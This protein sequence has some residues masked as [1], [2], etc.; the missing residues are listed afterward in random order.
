MSFRDV[1]IFPFRVF[2]LL[3]RLLSYIAWAP[4]IICLVT[5]RICYHLPR[6]LTN[7]P[8]VGRNVNPSQ[9]VTPSK[10]F[11]QQHEGLEPYQYEPLPGGRYIRL[12]QVKKSRGRDD[13][14]YQLHTM[15]LDHPFAGYVYRAISYAWDGQVP[16]RFIV[17][18][19]KKLAVTQNCETILRQMRR[20]AKLLMW[21][22]AVCIDLSSVNEKSTQ[23]PLMSKIYRRAFVVHIWMG[24]PT[25][26]SSI[27]F[28]YSWLLW[29]CLAFPEPVKSYL[30]ER[31]HGLILGT[32]ANLIDG[33]HAR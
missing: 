12:L 7:R 19:G 26:G 24:E 5:F 8:S 23:I 10:P 21:I 32:F 22:D 29:C 3:L 31:V 28:S 30:Q 4:Y 11:N 16:D 14:E 27:V 15:S 6:I 25:E 33:T 9:L 13:V 20:H 2:I 17:C 1:Y 18:S